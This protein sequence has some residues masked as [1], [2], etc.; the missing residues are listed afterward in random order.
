MAVAAL[1]RPFFMLVGGAEKVGRYMAS[2]A[3]SEGDGAF[4]QY[5][6]AAASDVRACWEEY[7][8]LVCAA[9]EDPPQ[10]GDTRRAELRMELHP[11]RR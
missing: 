7:A 9:A 10:E 6:I 8:A 11:A 2:G 5:L 4:G 1:A 3:R